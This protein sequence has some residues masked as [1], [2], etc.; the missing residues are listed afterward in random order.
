[1]IGV[2]AFLFSIFLSSTFLW[3]ETSVDTR[4]VVD[5]RLNL[6]FEDLE[7]LFNSLT[8]PKDGNI[9]HR[10]IRFK[11]YHLVKN[12]IAEVKNHLGNI[13]I[14][15]SMEQQE[16]QNI[17]DV[18]YDKILWIDDFKWA[19]LR[20]F[21]SPHYADEFFKTHNNVIE[22]TATGHERKE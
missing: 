14:E 6:S 1:M 8:P 10:S 11:K 9:L 7:S 17:L 19:P 16:I 3:A 18:L 22:K 2:F 13:D 4:S 15:S 20:H 5:N 12:N 21:S